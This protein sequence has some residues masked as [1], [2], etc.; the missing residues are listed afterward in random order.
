MAKQ[1][2]VKYGHRIVKGQLVPHQEE[3]KIIKMILEQSKNGNSQRKI[4]KTLN[5]K[6]IKSKKGGLWEKS[7]VAAIIKREI[8]ASRIGVLEA[9]SPVER[10]RVDEDNY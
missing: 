9:D 8:N 6:G 5:E 3:Q 1:L 4:A 10:R 2:R 7:V